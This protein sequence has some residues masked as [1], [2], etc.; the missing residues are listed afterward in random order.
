LGI[1][2]N[3][4]ASGQTTANPAT[5]PDFDKFRRKAL[6]VGIAAS[7]AYFNSSVTY[8]D[9][10]NNRRIYISPEGQLGLSRTQFIPTIYGFWHPATR[11]W[12]GFS[13]FTINR[14]G[15]SVNIDRD[16]GDYKVKGNIFMSDRSSFY[17]LSYNYLFFYDDRAFIL[18]A[19]GLYGIQLKAEIEAQGEIRIDD[20]PIESGYYKDN[21][22]RF[23]PFP[24]IGLQAQFAINERWYFGAGAAIVAGV[25]EDMAAFA[26]ES[27]ISARFVITKNFSILGELFFFNL[28]T[29]IDNEK[30]KTKMRYGFTALF[31]GIDIGY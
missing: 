9:K 22:D 18:G 31:L 27:K 25:F 8:Y 16:L 24:L 10:I 29:Q 21:V 1:G 12:V 4:S 7:Y 23:A 5:D 17:N 14:E 2:L 15:N 26:F 13:Y 6:S 20:E 3:Y 19:L 11:H 28:D 30:E